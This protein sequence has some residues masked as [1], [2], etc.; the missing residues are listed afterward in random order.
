MRL[1]YLQHVPF[2][3]LAKI[4]DWAKDRGHQISRTLVYDGEN[5]PKL[6]EFDWLII[7]G[8]PM[9]I[10]EEDKYPWLVKEKK[11]I[12]EAIK[13]N[14]VVLGICLGGQLIADVLGGKVQRNA[15]KEIGW[16]PVKLTKEVEESKIFRV[17]P[18]EFM[19]FHWHGDIFNIP[20]KAIRMAESDGCA[21]QAFVFNKAV[22]LQFHLESSI[23]SINHLINNCGNELVEGKYIQG[24]KELLSQVGLFPQ[25][26]RLMAVF[27][28]NM[29]KEFS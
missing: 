21:N 15:H 19:A 12:K 9:N 20:P 17:L 28:D 7:M 25:I 16:H 29:E 6:G 22:A 26:N 4:E 1:H 10:Y 3:D 5:F 8:G 2:E 24:P 27:L 11:F 18:K 14:K 13:A 23:E